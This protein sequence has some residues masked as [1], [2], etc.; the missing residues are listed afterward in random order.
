MVNPGEGVLVQGVHIKLGLGGQHAP[1]PGRLGLVMVFWRL[2]DALAREGGESF[3][4]EAFV[5]GDVH[6]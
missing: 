3:C 1:G 4:Q 5:G 2:E 6:C